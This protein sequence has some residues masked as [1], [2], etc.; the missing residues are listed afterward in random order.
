MF[1]AFA[2]CILTAVSVQAQKRF[3]QTGIA[4]FYAEDFHGKK[5][6]SGE[7][8]NMGAFT[9]A[10]RTLPFHTLVK[11]TNLSNKK[12]VVVRINDAGPFKEDRI[13]DLSRAAANKIGMTKKGTAKVRLDVVGVANSPDGTEPAENSEYYS[14]TLK[15]ERLTGYAI[16]A[17]SFSD[18]D[19]LIHQSDA[20]KS[21]GFTNIHVQMATV[22][23]E[24]VHRVIIGPYATRAAADAA[25]ARLKNAGVSGFVVA[26]R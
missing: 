22:K 4:S 16:Q 19:H 9:A 26:I 18:L 12:S 7:I 20:L 25:L 15:N 8:Y 5:T 13:I 2:F 11:V 14:F 1:S 23:H 10:H 24:R 17:G 6:S 21:K 3:T